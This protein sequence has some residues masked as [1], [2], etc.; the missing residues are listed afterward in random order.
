MH[1]FSNLAISLDGKIAT[2]SRELFLLG[3]RRD[4]QE[5]Q[6][7]RKLADA[8]LIG[9]TTLRSYKKPNLV[10]GAKIQPM[11]ALFSSRLD[12]I[13]PNWPFFQEPTIHRVLFVGPNTPIERLKKFEKKSEIVILKAATK[14]NPT[15]LQAVQWLEKKGVKN[16][17]VEGGGAVMWDFSSAHLIQEYHVTLTPKII[18]GARSSTLVDGVGFLPKEVLN[19]KLKQCR[20]I[21]DEIYLIYR[22]K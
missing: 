9:A 11:N 19:L 20:V 12:K 7:L 5:M 2:R 3:S 18:G 4:H 13:S 22:V 1:I 16:L 17:L 8:I 21:G 15:S 10:N 14:K 6:R